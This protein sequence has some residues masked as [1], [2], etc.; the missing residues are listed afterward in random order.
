VL[1]PEAISAC[2]NAKRPVLNHRRL[3]VC[4]EVI[5]DIE[6]PNEQSGRWK[7]PALQVFRHKEQ[8]TDTEAL[9]KAVL[10]ALRSSP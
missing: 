10:A 7:N 6:P 1:L 3:R 8:L 9:Q 2:V 5:L 4:K